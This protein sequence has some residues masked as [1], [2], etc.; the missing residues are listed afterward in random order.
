[1]IYLLTYWLYYGL[2]FFLVGFHICDWITKHSEDG[3]SLWC[4]SHILLAGVATTTFILT[5]I[6]F[7]SP[8][9]TTAHVSFVGIL[10][11]L[12]WVRAGALKTYWCSLYSSYFVLSSPTHG[13]VESQGGVGNKTVP[14]VLTVFFLLIGS[15][16]CLIPYVNQLSV[17]TSNEFSGNVKVYYDIGDGYHEQYSA[18]LENE[19][20]STDIYRK[21]LVSKAHIEKIRFDIGASGETIRL[22]GVVINDKNIAGAALKNAFIPLHDITLL[23]RDNSEISYLVTGDDPSFEIALFNGLLFSRVTFNHIS[24][25]VFSALVFLLL[26]HYRRRLSLAIEYVAKLAVLNSRVVIVGGI[27]ITL[28]MILAVYVSS[29]VHGYPSQYDTD[30]YHA[31]TVQWIKEYSVVP[32]LG[33]IHLRLA[34][35]NS[36]FLLAAFVDV[37]HFSGKSYHLL[38]SFFYLVVVTSVMSYVIAGCVG[39]ARMSSLYAL[40]LILPLVFYVDGINSLSTDVVCNLLVVYL[41][42][43]TLVLFETTVEPRHLYLLLL[44]VCFGITVKLTLVPFVLLPFVLLPWLQNQRFVDSRFARLRLFFILSS[45]T[46]ILLA[47]WII[48]GIVQTGYVFWPLPGIDVFS[49]DWKVP[50]EYIKREILWIKSWPYGITPDVFVRENTIYWLYRWLEDRWAA[51]LFTAVLVGVFYLTLRC[52]QVLSPLSKRLTAL[53]LL[54]SVAV[55]YWLFNAPDIRFGFG[56]V[57]SYLG[58]MA[59]SCLL[60]IMYRRQVWLKGAGTLT[61]IAIIL[62]SIH[63]IANNGLV[64]ANLPGYQTYPLE[65][66][67]FPSG[68]EV[69]TT[70]PPEDRC[71]DAPI[72]CIPFHYK[73]FNL[74]MRGTS[75]SNGF[76]RI[77]ND[78]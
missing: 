32:G 49:F 12:S 65:K 15:V 68:M 46:L 9:D 50:I 75:F 52:S 61:L 37:F 19:S 5:L 22:Y 39:K 8:I 11:V 25:L 73:I 42:L 43:Q 27:F 63:G 7:F 31:Q 41:I 16:F 74:E 20:P 35:N 72:P 14:L 62:T 17:H 67:N 55:L 64:F 58:M 30:L 69:L 10:L 34:F 23:N 59:G 24:F 6:H 76:R 48:R 4:I 1:M 33:N 54:L 2:V 70:L 78:H 44:I 47:P 56:I 36:W 57:A 13:V 26:V 45:S 77:R 60:V 28:F 38:N 71:G 40:V 21:T 3:S 29:I 18:A 66:Y 51:L 53:H